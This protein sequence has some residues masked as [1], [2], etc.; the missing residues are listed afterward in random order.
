[1]RDPYDRG[2]DPYFDRDPVERRLLDDPYADPYSRDP[3]PRE[4][5]VPVEP[6]T[7]L[8]VPAES[9]DY[10]HGPAAKAAVE[11]VATIGLCPTLLF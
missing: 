9:I 7:R 10:G 8:F 4:R 11:E 6:E 1:M 5:P 2:Y 3:W